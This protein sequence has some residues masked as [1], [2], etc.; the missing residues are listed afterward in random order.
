MPTARAPGCLLF[1]GSFDPIHLGHIS[2]CRDVADQLSIS[3]VVLIPCAVP[4][5]KPAQRLA[6][7]HH[8]FEMC[9]LAAEADERLTVSDWELGQPGPSY[10]LRTLEHFADIRPRESLFWMIGMDALRDLHKWYR[11]ADALALCTFV[12]AA[13]PGF[14]PPNL[15]A[16]EE[17]VGAVQAERVRTHIV[18]TIEV[19]VSSTVIR[20]AVRAGRSVRGRVSDAVA[21]YIA[22][23][24]LYR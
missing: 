5:H 6:D 20:E 8:R 23:H 14:A 22:A 16:L 13:R 2:V 3:H 17:V 18:S 21:D 19:D 10:T 9:R 4:P 1:G 24:G 7:G 15:D 12:T 11:I